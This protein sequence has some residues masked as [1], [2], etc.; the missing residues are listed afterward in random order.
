MT[1]LGIVLKIFEKTSFRTLARTFLII[2]S[3]SQYGFLPRKSVVLQLLTSL[4]R[5]YGNSH[6]AGHVNLLTLFDFSKAIDK[7]R[8]DIVLKKLTQLG[9]SEKL[10]N[11]LQDYLPG[12]TQRVKNNNSLSD[13]MNITSGV[14]QRSFLGPF[15]FLIYINDLRSVVFSSVALLFADDSKLIYSGSPEQLKRL[16]S[17][18][19]N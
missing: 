19:E 9:V 5:K 4:S 16:Q 7:I 17:D 6:T 12:R 14:P 11:L 10:F 3:K 1:L 8:H 15:F 18:I 13:E 2:V